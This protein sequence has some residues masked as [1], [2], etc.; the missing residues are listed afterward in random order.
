[1]FLFDCIL[2]YFFLRGYFSLFGFNSFSSFGGDLDGHNN[3]YSKDKRDR[4]EFDEEV[5]S[6]M[7]GLF[8]SEEG[9][10]KVRSCFRGHLNSFLSCESC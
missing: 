7:G 5:F 4:E 6:H 2:V 3:E 9:Q 1:M 10:H 8:G